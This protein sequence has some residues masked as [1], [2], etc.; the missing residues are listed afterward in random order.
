[1]DPDEIAYKLVELYLREVSKSHEKR[2]MGLDTIMNAY[3]YALL[4]IQRKKKELE[5][6][7][8][9]VEKESS[10]E[11]AGEEVK[12]E[13]PEKTEEKEEDKPLEEFEFD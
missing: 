11:I 8:K 7:E 13:K 1:M 12:E 10:E 6:L 4:R 9:V 3:F 5:A 2:Q